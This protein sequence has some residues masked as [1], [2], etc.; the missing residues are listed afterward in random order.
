MFLHKLIKDDGFYELEQFL[1]AI[2]A[3]EPAV[4][5]VAEKEAKHSSPLFLQRFAEALCY[6]SAMFESFEATLPPSSRERMVVEKMWIGREIEDIVAGEGEGRKERYERF[7]RW[8]GLMKNAG[9]VIKPLSSFAL[10]QAR[11][12]L[13]LHYPSE[14]Y[15]VEMMKGSMF[16]GW[17][18][19]PLY[20]VSSWF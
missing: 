18:S 12:L 6:Y 17:K 15:R 8:E 9:F 20:S 11:L 2:K 7:E 4:V 10:A 1:Q 3:M 5:T 13:R 14:G 19:K 16:L